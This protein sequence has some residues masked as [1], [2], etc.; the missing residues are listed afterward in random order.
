MQIQGLGDAEPRPWE[1]PLAKRRV[2]LSVPSPVAFRSPSCRNAAV[3]VLRPT[4]PNER[5]HAEDFPGQALTCSEPAGVSPSHPGPVPCTVTGRDRS[6]VPSLTPTQPQTP[7][8]LSI[9]P[10][11]EVSQPP[12]PL[13]AHAPN[14]PHVTAQPPTPCHHPPPPPI[15]PPTRPPPPHPKAK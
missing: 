11:V 10:A 8:T 9:P 2:H 6:S 5:H 4:R 12:T 13:T 3:M 1:G 15:S 14:T 7:T